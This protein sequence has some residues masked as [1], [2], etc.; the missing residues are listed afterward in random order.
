L[1]LEGSVSNTGEIYISAY[2]ISAKY[3]ISRAITFLL[4]TGASDSFISFKDARMI[5]IDFGKLKKSEFVLGIGGIVRSYILDDVILLTS[6]QG[7]GIFY[8]RHFRELRVFAESSLPEKAALGLP[9]ILGRDFLGKEFSIKVDA[10]SKKVYLI[11]DHAPTRKMPEKN[12]RQILDES[13]PD[14]EAFL[15]THSFIGYPV[16]FVRNLCF[17]LESKLREFFI[18][19]PTNEREIQDEIEKALI[20]RN[21][22]YGRENVTFQYGPKRYTPDFNFPRDDTVL[23]AKFCKN[24]NRMKEISE[25]MLADIAAYNIKY[26]HQV[27]IV[28]D[29]GVIRHMLQFKR[30]IEETH[31]N[32]VI[33]V[34]K[35]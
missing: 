32:V 19:K 26:K 29:L 24:P 6:A 18:K 35:D 33:I 22:E 5:G 4:D 15:D 16:D 12:I 27:F 11:C 25:E 13:K 23:E 7:Q 2:V 1:R 30:E 3:R 8:T 21:Y 14:Q 9:S 34:I 10:K 17:Y 20:A 28:Y 31:K